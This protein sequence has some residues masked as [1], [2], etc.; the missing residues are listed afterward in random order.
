MSYIISVPIK[1]LKTTIKN[2]KLACLNDLFMEFEF[3]I[4][5]NYLI[6]DVIGFNCDGSIS[7][8]IFVKKNKNDKKKFNE[9]IYCDFCN[10][11]LKINGKCNH[12]SL[13]R[14]KKIKNNVTFFFEHKTSFT[15]QENDTG[16]IVFKKLEE[17]NI[18]S[19]IYYK[20]EKKKEKIN[21]SLKKINEICKKIQD[22]V[23]TFYDNNNHYIKKI[24]SEREY[25]IISKFQ[26]IEHF[27]KIHKFEKIG[28]KYIVDMPFYNSKK[29]NFK[30][31]IQFVKNYIRALLLSIKSMNEKNYVHG[32]IKPNNFIYNNLNDYFLI[33]F[34]SSLELS[35][36]LDDMNHFQTFPFI[37]PECNV[38]CYHYNSIPN[39]KSDLWS[40]GIILLYF[41]AEKEIFKKI[42]IEQQCP[43]RRNSLFQYINLYG[44]HESKIKKDELLINKDLQ[45]TKFDKNFIKN[46]IKKSNKNAIDLMEKLLELYTKDRITI[47]EALNHDFLK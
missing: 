24:M 27:P 29:L 16:K 45:D 23:F 2:F 28:N 34:D 39:K 32:D 11:C 7:N 15:L 30:E 47:E 4:D 12:S 10:A 38:L 33:D 41:L 1:H 13:C 25:T 40:V 19:Q 9:S 44:K 42:I 22:N 20:K 5:Q 6:E 37:P 26:K 14:K 36:N 35:E 18:A 21:D 3:N 31:N 17:K 8:R 46:N 43:N